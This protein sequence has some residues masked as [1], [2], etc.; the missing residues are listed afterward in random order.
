[1][2]HTHRLWFGLFPLMLLAAAAAS[3][4][5]A[6][7]N[8]ESSPISLAI[9]FPLIGLSFVVSGLIA[10]TLR[11]DNGTGRLLVAVGLL[12]MLSALWEANNGWLYG[13][14]AF[15]GSLFLA[16][17]VHLMLAFPSGR[18]ATRLERGTVIAVWVIAVVAN[19]LPTL[20]TKHSSDC[21]DCPDNPYLIRDSKPVADTLQVFFSVLGLVIFAGVVVLLIR[22]WRRATQAQRRILGPVYL[23][24]GVATALVAALFVVSSFSDRSG[25]VLGVVTFIAFGTVPLFFLAG[26]LR[27]RLYRPAARLLREVPDEPSPEEVQA[28]LRRV[29]G[30]PTL[31]FLT[32]IDE[33]GGYVDARGNPVQLKPDSARRATTRIDR[34]SDGHPLAALVHDSALLLQRGVLDE[35]VSAARLAIEKDRGLQAMRRSEMRS[36]ALLDAIPDLMFRIAR[37]GTYLEVKGDPSRMVV[38]PEEL[39]GRSVRDVLPRDLADRFEEA[40]AAPASKGVQTV[41]Y[42]LPIADE[43]RYF[44]AR[45]VPS[46]NDEVVVIVRDFTDRARLEEEL[47]RRLREVQHEQEFTRAVVNTAPIVLMLCDDEGRIVRFNDTTEALFGFADDEEM[48]GRFLWDAFVVEEDRDAVADAFRRVHPLRPVE[49]RGRWSTRD[50]V[51]RTIDASVAHI[52]DGQG[53][54]RRIVAGL[55]ITDLVERG[56]ELKSQRDFLTVVARATPSLLITV[57]R[58]GTVA[59]E[60]VNYA[61]RELTGYADEQSIGRR[62]WDL[63]APPEL[64]DEIKNAFHEQVETGVSIEHETAWIGRSG[65]WR[66][67]A[68]WLR[69]LGEPADKFIV[70]GT[71]IT[72]R[73]AQEAEL[74]ASRSRIVEA[75]DDARMRLER[76]LHDGAQQ[77]L[78]SLSLALRLAQSRLR[79]DPEA[80][81][82]LLAGASEELTQALAELRE[83]ARGIHPA[84]LTDR[85]L[86]AAL[87]ALAAR[88]PLPVEL[89]T[90]LDERLP[91]PVEAA[92]YYVVSEALTN[93]AKYSEASAVEVRAERQNGRVVVEVADDGIGG[94]DP[95]L[96]SGLRGL[97]DRVE[98]LD[99]ALEVESSAGEGT[100]VRAVIPLAGL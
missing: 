1:M 69:P 35:V 84:V 8:H 86:P 97:A 18:L 40:L 11:P 22:R 88:A 21:K 63:V 45:M 66:I 91:S 41:E 33:M 28:G 5:G 50:G 52:I 34:E 94:A 30:D 2:R 67:V 27:D 16:A 70:C 13:L 54:S 60:G 95:S 98:A 73:K 77:R 51:M 14:G 100:T 58:D 17:F 55:D 9:A 64:V 89:S 24:G 37:D 87:E 83:L 93:V 49:V 74:R 36:R 59:P 47:A 96:G 29:L 3:V 44:E 15:A 39:L 4:I 12:W 38:P 75:A 57:E 26:L 99:G 23:S 31:Q 71:D 25:N 92:A 62:F 20:F 90:D 78:V 68:W 72:E 48:R 81:E 43:E 56:E 65:T 61:F 19:V 42:R 85:G 80:A 82:Q 79:D 53:L 7:S 76:N 46:G 6:I 10:W 32:W